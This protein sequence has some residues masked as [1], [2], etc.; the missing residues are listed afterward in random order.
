VSQK[1]TT[2]AFTLIQ[3]ALADAFAFA[4]VLSCELFGTYLA[5]TLR[6]PS[7]LGMISWIQS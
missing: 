5:L 6:K 4:H 7:L 2:F 1:S 3:K